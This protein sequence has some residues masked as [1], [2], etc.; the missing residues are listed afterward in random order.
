MSG[1]VIVD[2]IPESLI[3]PDYEG[4]YLVTPLAYVNQIL[5]TADKVLSEDVVVE[6][7][8]YYETTNDAGGYTAIIG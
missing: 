1:N 3:P 6:Q 7:I 8:P 2:P 4:S 5:R